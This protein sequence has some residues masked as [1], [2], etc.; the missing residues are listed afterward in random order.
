MRNIYLS[1]KSKINVSSSEIVPTS[2]NDGADVTP[3]GTH[4]VLIPRFDTAEPD[5][6]ELRTSYDPDL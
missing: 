1:R 6:R 2:T 3:P 5:E 4:A